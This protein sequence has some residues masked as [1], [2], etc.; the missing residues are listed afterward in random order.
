MKQSMPLTQSYLKKKR[1]KKRK[2]KAIHAKIRGIQNSPKLE[3]G[4]GTQKCQHFWSD[5]QQFWSAKR[6]FQSDKWQTLGFWPDDIRVMLKHILFDFLAIRTRPDLY[7][8]HLSYFFKSPSLR[9][10]RLDLKIQDIFSH[11]QISPLSNSPFW[12]F[13]SYVKEVLKALILRISFL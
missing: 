5:D 8:D 4:I 9:K 10:Q 13:P 6:H 7:F 3:S 12:Y 2:R 1:E 11:P